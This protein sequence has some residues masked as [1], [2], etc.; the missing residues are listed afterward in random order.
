MEKVFVIIL[1]IF[2]ILGI[3]HVLE[4]NSKI[5]KQNPTSSDSEIAGKTIVE[6]SA[7][8]LKIIK[9]GIDYAIT[10]KNTEIPNMTNITKNISLT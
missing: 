7:N 8:A 2:L 10:S 5:T 6:E 9:S 4:T 1:L 3:V